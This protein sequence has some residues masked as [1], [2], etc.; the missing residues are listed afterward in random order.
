MQGPADC[1]SSVART[2]TELGA[3]SVPLTVF[4]E[5]KCPSRRA[6]DR[7]VS[8][9]VSSTGSTGDLHAPP[10]SHSASPQSLED[11]GRSDHGDDCRNVSS[12][13]NTP[14]P[15]PCRSRRTPPKLETHGGV[16][17]P[18]G[19]PCRPPPGLEHMATAKGS[20]DGTSL[21]ELLGMNDHASG[22]AFY[23][24]RSVPL[25][26]EAVDP[27]RSPTFAAPFSPVPGFG[28]GRFMDPPVGMPRQ[29]IKPFPGAVPNFDQ[30]C[31]IAAAQ[32]AA[33][34]LMSPT[35]GSA[36]VS[37]HLMASM[38]GAVRG[39]VAPF[40][41]GGVI[42]PGGALTPQRAGPSGGAKFQS[43][44]PTSAIGGL[45]GSPAG[46]L[47]GQNCMSPAVDPRVPGRLVESSALFP[48]PQA[49]NLCD[50]LETDESRLQC[51]GAYM[52]D[53]ERAAPGHG[54]RQPGDARSLNLLDL[55]QDD[56]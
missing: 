55:L 19:A 52:N 4:L 26:S 7:E 45:R 36:G 21:L 30:A 9:T 31:H 18:G 43:P 2:D 41:P 48:S 42:Q 1:T 32:M 51:S 16:T 10:R 27:R 47:G 54:A 29:L 23:P 20:G 6:D 40:S 14:D 34:S 13:F 25:A 35:P 44:P 11:S 46:G 3:W 50:L 33:L 38:S 53:V 5:S 15:V 12:N 39:G 17:S 49:I 56:K 28:N 8:S 24:P 37:P 22:R